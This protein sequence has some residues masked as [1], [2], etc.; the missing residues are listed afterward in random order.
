MPYKLKLDRPPAGYA[1]EHAYKGDRVKIVVREFTSS[2]DGELFVSRLEGL[3]SEILRLLP[4]DA[5]I[6]PSMIDHLLVIIRPDL[7]TVVYVNECRIGV[8]I[9]AARTI[10]AGDYVRDDDIVDIETLRFDGV[11]IPV[12]AGVLC[13]FSSGWRKGLFFDLTPLHPAYR[14]GDYSLERVLGSYF[15]YLLNQTVFKLDESHWRLLFDQGWFPFVTLPRASSAR[16]RRL[17]VA[18]W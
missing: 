3:P 5:N 14:V 17:S 2:E 13:V 4:P 15:A 18:V 10:Q 8:R 1:V 9:R 12:D 6:L 11:E 7:E 16:S